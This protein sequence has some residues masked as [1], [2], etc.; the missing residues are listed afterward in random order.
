MRNLQHKTRRKASALMLMIW[1]IMLMSFTVGSTVKYI[2]YSVRE[3]SYAANQFRALHLAESG[4]EVAFQQGVFASVDLEM[5]VV[6]T[7][8]SITFRTE[9]EEAKLPVNYVT[10]ERARESIYSIF[11]PWMHIK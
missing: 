7:D 6:G 11:I 4:A 10:D 9:V 5:P 8:S 3:S 1:A 2:D